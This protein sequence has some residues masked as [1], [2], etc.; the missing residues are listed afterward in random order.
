MKHEAEAVVIGAGAWGASVAFHLAKAGMRDV[1][2]LDKH[3]VASQ[4]SPRAAGLSGQ[5]RTSELMTRL[6]V[7]AVKKIEQFERETGEPLVY[8]QPGSLKIARTAEHEAQ[9]RA[10]VRRGRTLG[11]DVDFVSRHEAQRLQPFL[12]ANGVRAV[13]YNPTDVYLEPAQIPRGYARAAERLGVEVLPKTA[14]VGIATEAGAVT[15]V[16]TERGEVR[17]NVVVDAAGA[18][19]RGVAGMAGGTMAIVPTRHQLLITDPIAGVDASQPIARVID[20]NVYIRPE[21]GGLMLGGYEANPAQYDM[22]TQP[23]DFQIE[24]LPLD[25]GVLRAL[26]EAIAP[27]FPIFREFTVREHRGGLPTMT[28]D[29]EHIVGPMPGVRGF[30]LASG[31]CVGGLSVAPAI[32]ELLGQWIISG[33]PPMD[34]TPLSPARFGPQDDLEDRLRHLCRWQYAHH[35]WLDKHLREPNGRA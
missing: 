33:S 20:A 1:L 4:T 30:F 17:T 13:T 34:L 7:R 25:L 26:A 31:C 21:R 22:R 5:V 18:W 12:D 29:G 27:Q 16:V 19:A 24:D 23:R 14:V 8:Y 32:G 6:A 2:L 35:Y 28:P 9:L 15:R 11:L 10:E 3:D